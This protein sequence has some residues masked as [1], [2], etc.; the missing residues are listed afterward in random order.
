MRYYLINKK[1]KCKI[2]LDLMD[3][4]DLVVEAKEEDTIHTEV[5]LMVLED[6]QTLEILET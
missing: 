5:D 2:D 4:K 3:H 1:D 6:F